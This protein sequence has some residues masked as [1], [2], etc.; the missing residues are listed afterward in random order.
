MSLATLHA[1]P[2]WVLPAGPV[3]YTTE[4]LTL[5]LPKYFRTAFS[6]E[7]YALAAAQRVQLPKD[8][9][10]DVTTLGNPISRLT[11]CWPSSTFVVWKI[12]H[13]FGRAGIAA[14]WW[15]AQLAVTPQIPERALSL[16]AD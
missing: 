3:W 12:K 15:P 11:W 9:V 8:L 7:I 2:A 10:Y 14:H 6:L 16:H 1:H 13:R 5:L 4:T